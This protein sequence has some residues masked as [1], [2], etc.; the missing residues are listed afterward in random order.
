[1][2]PEDIVPEVR[3][4]ARERHVLEVVRAVDLVRPLVSLA[5]VLESI[6]RLASHDSSKKEQ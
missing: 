4:E 3:A 1:V 5:S 2:R 6:E